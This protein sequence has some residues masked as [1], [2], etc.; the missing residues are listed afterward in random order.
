[1]IRVGD[2]V[3]LR[4][5]PAFRPGVVAFNPVC[6]RKGGGALHKGGGALRKG[7]VPILRNTIDH[8]FPLAAWCCGAAPG[9]C[10]GSS[11]LV[12]ISAARRHRGRVAAEGPASLGDWS[13]GQGRRTDSLRERHATCSWY[14]LS[15]VIGAC[16]PA[17]GA[18]S[19]ALL[20]AGQVLKADGSNVA[21]YFPADHGT[22][23]EEAGKWEH[24]RLLNT[25]Q[26][27]KTTC[28][29]WSEEPM[30][31][32]CVDNTPQLCTL[33]P[34]VAEVLAVS[35]V[36][37]ST[38]V[39]LA[40]LN[41]PGSASPSTACYYLPATAQPLKLPN[42]MVTGGPLDTPL[43]LGRGVTFLPGPTR[44]SC[45]LRVDNALLSLTVGK[46][47][48]QVGPALNVGVALGVAYGSY[49]TVTAKSTAFF[50]QSAV[51]PRHELAEAVAQGDV[52]AVE[53]ILADPQRCE[54]AVSQHL[55]GRRNVLHVAA[56]SS[57]KSLPNATSPLHESRRA[58]RDVLMELLCRELKGQLAV[59]LGQLDVTG[60]TP[61]QSALLHGAYRP[62]VTM[63][64]AV[65]AMYPGQ[66]SR[67]GSPSLTVVYGLSWS[68]SACHDLSS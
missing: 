47:Q 14:C 57:A 59:L 36:S 50:L 45:L 42:V 56:A 52:A 25:K 27:F 5:C 37:R 33:P 44:G 58:V 12:S 39:I 26:L 41:P 38:L 21:V 23:V 66:L 54:G 61:F 4:A 34:G 15:I 51:C 29:A 8:P 3:A 24:S 62:A 32:K 1:M 46:T 68:V 53:A 28:T 18:C 67:S 60:R 11:R 10:L 48:T 30:L 17:I 7:A 64:N 31:G 19:P 9:Q 65:K 16:S 49:P 22:A 2:T 13:G 6:L 43:T 20:K 55:D 35:V 63:V 40:T